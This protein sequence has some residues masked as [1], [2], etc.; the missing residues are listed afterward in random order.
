MTQEYSKPKN[1]INQDDLRLLKA[2]IAHI[3][4]KQNPMHYTSPIL[5]AEVIELMSCSLG[6]FIL[7]ATNK[8]IVGAIKHGG[9]IRDRNLK[10]ELHEEFLDTFWYTSAQQWPTKNP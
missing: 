2:A 9:D 10:T 4:Q 1:G 7:A 6:D 8:F 5:S 3:I